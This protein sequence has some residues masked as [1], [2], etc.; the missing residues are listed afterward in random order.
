[1]AK[2]VAKKKSTNIVEFDQEL[3]LA[4]S[5]AGLEGMTSED[6]MI[7]RITILQQMSPA[8]NKRDGAY[9][10]GADPG[11]ILDN[12]ARQAVDGE[13]GITVVPVSY[14]RSHIEWKKDRGGFVR[15]HGS[16]PGSMSKSQLKKAR[17]WNSMIS[18][19]QVPHPTDETKKFSPAMFWNAYKLTTVP[20][21]NDQGSW[22][23]WDIEMMYDANSGGI[24]QNIKTGRDIY[25]AA[26]DF[27]DQVN[28]GEVKVS[29][30]TEEDP[31]TM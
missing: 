5:G 26:R 1:M 27:K 6:F 17:R 22:F 9:V 10:E 29:P 20:E 16:D 7:P 25:L 31:D 19:L 15:D 8:V 11:H 4:D 23:N 28:K 21:E 18:K 14:R 12:V 3:L 2:E 30:D 13:V 24:I